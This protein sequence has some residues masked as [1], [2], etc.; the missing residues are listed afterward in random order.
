LGEN[1]SLAGWWENDTGHIAAVDEM[2]YEKSSV[3]LILNHAEVCELLPLDECIPVMREAFIALASGKVHLPLRSIIRPTQAKGLLGLMPSYVSGEH[4]AY[5]L[6]AVCVFPGNPAI[7][8]DAHQGAVL[9][10]SGETGDLQAI[11]NAS[12]IT[13]IRT[14]AAT[15]V[16]TDLLARKDAASLA[17]L[18]SGVQARTHLLAMAE[19]RELKQCRIA[20]RYFDH[21]ENFA[22]E[23]SRQVSFAVEPVETVAEALEGAD[24]IVST[25]TAREPIVKREWIKPGSHLNLVGA[26]VPNAREADGQTLAAASLFVDSRESALNEAGDYILAAQEGLIG[27][28]HI[29][30]ELGEVLIGTKPGRT[31]AEE[32]TCFKSLGIAVEDLFAAEYLCRKAERLKVGTWVEY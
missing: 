5:G 21:A 2:S 3:I 30:A 27:P 28:D 15:A 10:F 31:S 29:R 4:S 11:M 20:S 6:K 25:T 12:A 22:R 7:G 13:A 24:L 19:V 18:G 8:K 23:M 1:I 14:A 16:A 32:I 26:C 17:I 9:L